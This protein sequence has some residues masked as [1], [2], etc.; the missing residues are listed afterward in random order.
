MDETEYRQRLAAEK[1]KQ[2]APRADD[3]AKQVTEVVSRISARLEL[4]KRDA[5]LARALPLLEELM[6]KCWTPSQRHPGF[7]VTKALIA[8]IR[9][10]GIEGE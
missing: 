7:T 9:A 10:L 6:R 1:N 2:A 5:L 8:E 4:D 3:T